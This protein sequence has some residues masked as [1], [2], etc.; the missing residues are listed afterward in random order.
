MFWG[1]VKVFPNDQGGKISPD[2]LFRGG[3]PASF[4][5]AAFVPFSVYILDTFYLPPVFVKLS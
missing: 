5:N 4:I 2:T 1:F 3:V